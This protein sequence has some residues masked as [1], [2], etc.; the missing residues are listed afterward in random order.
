MNTSLIF[1]IYYRNDFDIVLRNGRLSLQVSKGLVFRRSRPF[2]LSKII[3][4]PNYYDYA[5]EDPADPFLTVTFILFMFFLMWL[6]HEE[7]KDK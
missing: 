3:M 7:D 6:A 2:V 4:K 5:I 1:E